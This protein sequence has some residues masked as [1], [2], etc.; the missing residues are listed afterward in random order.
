MIAYDAAH[1]KTS[2]WKLIKQVEIEEIIIVLLKS[3]QNETL[4]PVI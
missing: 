2:S 1:G 4:K 3:V